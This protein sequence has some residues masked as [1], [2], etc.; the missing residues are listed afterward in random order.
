MLARLALA[1]LATVSAATSQAA[2]LVG[3]IVDASTIIRAAFG[4][5]GADTFGG[6]CR[7][8]QGS[9]WTCARNNGTWYAIRIDTANQITGIVNTG[10][11]SSGSIYDMTFDAQRENVWIQFINSAR[12]ISALTGTVLATPSNQSRLGLAWDGADRVYIEN[13]TYHYDADAFNTVNNAGVPVPNTDQGLAFTAATGRFWGGR[14]SHP[15][16]MGIS[17]KGIAEHP[18]P[19]ATM[20]TEL[21]FA[22]DPAAP[23]TNRGGALAGMDAWEDPA[24]GEWLGV[25]C[26][27][28]STGDV[29]LYTARLSESTGGNCGGPSFSAGPSVVQDQ[30]YASGA[31]LGTFAWLMV[32]FNH[33]SFTAPIFAPGCTVEI[34]P[35]NPT[36]FG[37]YL[38]NFSGNMSMSEPVPVS[39]VLHEAPLYFQWVTLDFAGNLFLSEGR[40]AAI[41][42]F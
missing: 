6:V 18:T 2:Q 1:S 15:E 24:T 27:R 19:G 9:Y 34:D 7:D 3:P 10:D 16:P 20:P 32:S 28:Q 23:A 26:Q 39:P 17:F 14:N 13:H 40:S 35:V 8:Q 4:F 36:I 31:N 30:L 11:S 37:A 29:K 12:V 42:Q 25:F 33:A 41:K 21:S 5:S 38:P 22:Y